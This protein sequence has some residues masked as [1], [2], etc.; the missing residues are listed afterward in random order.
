[1][2]MIGNYIKETAAAPGAAA[3]FY[4]GG[5]TAPFRTFRS[6]LA[7][8]S[9]PFY[10][11]QDASQYEFGISTLT[12]GSPDTLT[13]TTVL[14]NSAGT[15]VKLTFSGTTTVYNQIPAEKLDFFDATGVKRVFSGLRHNQSALVK[16][17]ADEA[18][19]TATGT[20]IPWDAAE[21]DD[22][23]MWSAGN[24]TRL[25]VPASGFARARL[26]AGILW[27]G[28]ATGYRNIDIRKNGSLAAGAPNSTVFPSSAD[29]MAQLIASPILA[30]S[31]G[32]YF[33]VRVLQNSGGSLNV[34]ASSP[35]WFAMELI[36]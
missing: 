6:Q 2:S 3:T 34:G 15:T 13:R 25:T 32:D 26:Q 12:Y 36:R 9:T 14:G 27:G 22:N 18:I 5:A 24:P 19:A 28:H 8:G 7:N 16:L 33:E 10:W 29:T 17:T 31:P 11:M 20:S 23:S 21:Y 30:V 1:M 4:L 35:S